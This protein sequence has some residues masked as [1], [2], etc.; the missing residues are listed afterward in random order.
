MREPGQDDH[1]DD[2]DDRNLRDL[3]DLEDREELRTR[4]YGL[5]QELRVVIPGVQVLLA[6]LLTAPFA[7]RFEELDSRGRTLYAVALLTALAAVIALLAPTVMHRLGDRRARQAR[8]QWS[9]RLM[10]AGLAAL[11]VSLLSATWCV[12]RLV[13]GAETG[14]AAVVG[15]GL[16]VLL[17]W[18]ALPA[19]LQRRGPTSD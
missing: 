1:D 7:Q 16:L 4:Y 2:R 11:S 19:L 13:W 6:F 10:I 17:L 18:V 12:S 5:L 15:G 9:I 3:D 14:E 8:L